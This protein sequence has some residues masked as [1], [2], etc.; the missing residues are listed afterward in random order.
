M[1]KGKKVVL[2][3][4]GV[5]VGWNKTNNTRDDSL[6]DGTGRDG[7]GNPAAAYDRSREFGG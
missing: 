1:E 6:V 7:D 3:H 4:I 5:G 2:V